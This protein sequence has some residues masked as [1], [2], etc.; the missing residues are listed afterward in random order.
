[1]FE[2]NLLCHFT[3]RTYLAWPNKKVE[4]AEA[5]IR[6]RTEDAIAHEKSQQV[7]VENEGYGFRNFL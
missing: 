6:A 4:V 2:A 3:L 7:A 5:E 1:M